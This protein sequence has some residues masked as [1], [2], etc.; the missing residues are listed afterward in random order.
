MAHLTFE[1]AYEQFMERHV[2]IRSGERRGRLIRGHRHAEK[3]LL[4]QVWWPLFGSFERLH[5]EYEV[6]D[7]NRKSQFLDFAFLTPTGQFGI[8]CDG[9][10]SHVKDMDRERF[11]YSLNRDT[12]LTAMGW[13]MIRFS[14]DDVQQRP[15]ICRMLLQLAIGPHVLRMTEPAE[16]ALSPLE[17]E[18]LRMAC[19]MTA[20]IRTRDVSKRFNLGF[21]AA[22]G[23]LAR[24]SGLGL[25]TPLAKEAYVTGYRVNELAAKYL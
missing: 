23:P 19:K 5:P 9:Y 11:S 14:F 17:K 15:E 4:E 16:E 25:L 20:P 2:E 12:Y 6:M 8:E 7:W 1:A 3:L 24:L 22:R 10:Q 18:V 13:K 21:R